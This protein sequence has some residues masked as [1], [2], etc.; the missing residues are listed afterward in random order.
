MKII[1]IISVAGG[2][3]KTMMTASLAVLLARH[4][5]AVVAVE[6]DEQNMLG[7]WLGLGKFSGA[8]LATHA[9][10]RDGAWHASTFRNNDGVLFVP[11]GAVSSEALPSFDKLLGSNERWLADSLDEISLPQD[12]VVLID[13]ARFPGEKAMQAVRC[14]DLVICVARPD[15]AG[16]AALAWQ[17][18]LLR[19]HCKALKVVLNGVYPARQLHH[20]VI[21]MLK[22]RIGSDALLPIRIHLDE[23]VPRAY[24]RGGYF[25]DHAPHSQTSHDIHGLA[26]WLEAWT[27]DDA[28]A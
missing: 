10:H 20:D 25:F 9:I 18:A 19:Q 7:T 17:I 21:A 13:A 26:G 24:A 15:P 16:S 14:A 5:R 4:R 12:G 1:A 28:S 2:T 6:M 3:G 11:F 8:G 27:T 23:E 22:A